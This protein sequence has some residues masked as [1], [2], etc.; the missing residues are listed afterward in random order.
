M[1][2]NGM[3]VDVVTRDEAL[4]SLRPA[5]K[6]Q[7]RS[8]I[9]NPPSVASY[10]LLKVCVF[11][12]CATRVMGSW[13]LVTFFHEG[14]VMGSRR[15][16]VNSLPPDFVIVLTTPPVKRPYSAETPLVRSVVSWIASSMK[17]FSGWPGI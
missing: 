11:S 8:R 2:L 6:N 14:F 3:F 13:K 7:R 5:P 12:G 16:P 15:V 4:V 9:A 17:R 1:L 10:C